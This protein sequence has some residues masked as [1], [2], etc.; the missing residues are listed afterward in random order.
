MRRRMSERGQLQESPDV[1]PDPPPT[2]K[3]SNAERDRAASQE[4][5]SVR[6]HF[7]RENAA[8]A[9]HPQAADPPERR[10]LGFDNH[11]IPAHS[12]SSAPPT[13]GGATASCT[14]RARCQ[15][16]VSVGDTYGTP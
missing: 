11:R 14:I 12:H 5:L 6:R 2:E 8:I 13:T 3:G 16:T 4:C 9:L 10:G 15:P 7:Y 1:K